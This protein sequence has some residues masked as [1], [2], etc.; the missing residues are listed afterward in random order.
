VPNVERTIYGDH[1]HTPV[2][3]AYPFSLAAAVQASEDRIREVPGDAANYA[4][5]GDLYLFEMNWLTQSI[6]MYQKAEALAPQEPKYHWRL[7]DLYLNASRADRFLEELKLLA[8]RSPADPQARAW[9]RYYS[10]QYDF[11]SH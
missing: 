6:A 4:A 7:A 11:A 8:R 9:Y 1:A 5:L 10:E 3:A 2:R